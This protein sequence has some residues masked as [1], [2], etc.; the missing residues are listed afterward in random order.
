MEIPGAVF[1]LK[2]LDFLH[3]LVHLFGAEAF[4]VALK[5]VAEC[6]TPIITPTRRKI[7]QDEVRHKIFFK[8]QSIEIRRRQFG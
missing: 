5:M 6:A 8:W 4:H 2:E 3:D 7:G 1:I